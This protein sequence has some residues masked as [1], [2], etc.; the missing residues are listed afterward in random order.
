MPDNLCGAL[1]PK[2]GAGIQVQC[3]RAKDHI[4]HHSKYRRQHCDQRK[5]PAVYWEPTEEELGS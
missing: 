1:G 4:H 5:S 2:D 3:R